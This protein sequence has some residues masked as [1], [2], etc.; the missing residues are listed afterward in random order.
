MRLREGE[1]ARLNQTIDRIYQDIIR[2]GL[3]NVGM[4]WNGSGVV[5]GMSRIH[6]I[7]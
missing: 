5:S 4:G 1:P 2:K 7:A 6:V 3:D